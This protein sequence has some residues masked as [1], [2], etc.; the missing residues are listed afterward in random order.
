M[1]DTAT[2]TP[3]PCS[4]HPRTHQ[5]ARGGVNENYATC[6]VWALWRPVGLPLLGGQTAPGDLTSDTLP[7]AA[8]ISSPAFSLEQDTLPSCL[9]I[10]SQYLRGQQNLRKM[11]R[12]RTWHRL[13]RM[14]ST[15]VRKTNSSSC[16]PAH[17]GDRLA[18]ADQMH[19]AAGSTSPAESTTFA[20]PGL[21]LSCMKKKRYIILW[22]G[23]GSSTSGCERS[24][25]VAVRVSCISPSASALCFS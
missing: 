6:F 25:K 17:S 18:L 10:D 23:A 21:G 20:C 14:W 9:K 24:R 15:S 11:G 7:D 13:K 19:R 22:V 3:Q 2:R 1:L 16:S 8:A 4:S 5:S 12:R